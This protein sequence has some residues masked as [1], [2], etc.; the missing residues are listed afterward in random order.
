MPSPSKTD[1]MDLKNL[2]VNKLGR[3]C[4]IADVHGNDSCLNQ[5]IK[6][7]Q[8]GKYDRLFGVGDLVDRG[9][10]S[11]GVIET[12][13]KHPDITISEGNHEQ[14]TVASINALEIILIEMAD[15]YDAIDAPI[16]SQT[17]KDILVDDS[18]DDNKKNLVKSFL[19]HYENNGGEWLVALFLEEIENK[20]MYVIE[21]ENN[22]SQVDYEENSKMKMVKDFMV[23]LPCIVHVEGDERVMPFNTVHADM[24]ISDAVHKKMLVEKS[25]LT[26]EQKDYA[27]WTRIEGFDPSIRN[28]Y[29]TITYCGHNIMAYGD[30]ESVRLDSSMVNLDGAAFNTNI[31]LMVD[32][33]NRKV[34]CV[35]PEGIVEQSNDPRVQYLL[36]H[37]YYIAEY[38]DTK[39]L[40]YDMQHIIKRM[41]TEVNSG[42]N[43]NLRPIVD[44]SLGEITETIKEYNAAHPVNQNVATYSL[45]EVIYFAGYNLDIEDKDLTDFIKNAI[46]LMTVDAFKK[47]NNL[48]EMGAIV[49]TIISHLE[50]TNNMIEE[51]NEVRPSANPLDIISHNMLLQLIINNTT[52][53]DANGVAALKTCLKGTYFVNDQINELTD[54]IEFL[55]NSK[56]I[57]RLILKTFKNTNLTINNYNKRFP[58]YPLPPITRYELLTDCKKNCEF[59]QSDG[60]INTVTRIIMSA[61]T[62]AISTAGLSIHGQFSHA[63]NEKDR[64]EKE[65]EKTET[66]PRPRD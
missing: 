53:L 13:K 9:P 25:N 15:Q 59:L 44:K 60:N 16:L 55:T 11:V 18:S 37:A 28:K 48:T 63:A 41:V 51:F 10:N 43:D 24:P 40:T 42:N 38:L 56:E 4:V 2:T 5:V 14:L 39:K 3:D 36:D 32:H 46:A 62:P 61:L 12:L 45:Y 27:L 65:D 7:L 52:K 66:P 34:Y 1:L 50:D 26:P 54:S 6:Q 57:A 19:N 8:L 23:N 20:N 22:E 64:E 35:G 33:T 21:N 58:D 29:S 31:S 17:I 30:V 49:Q 47:I